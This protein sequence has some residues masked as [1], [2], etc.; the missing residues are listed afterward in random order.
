MVLADINRFGVEWMMRLMSEEDRPYISGVVDDLSGG[1]LTA[2]GFLLADIVSKAKS[3]PIEAAKSASQ[4]FRS[5][6]PD[7]DYGYLGADVIISSMLVT[8]M[9]MPFYAPHR[10]LAGLGIPE[11]VR[12]ELI[13]SFNDFRQRFY[14]NHEQALARA[15]AG[16]SHAAAVLFADTYEDLYYQ[17]ASSTLLG[18]GGHYLL[19]GNGTIVPTSRCGILPYYSTTGMVTYEAEH[20]RD[21]FLDMPGISVASHSTWQESPYFPDTDSPVVKLSLIHI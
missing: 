2:A 3:D 5:L 9:L 10:Y 7:Q 13:E 17:E 4:L 21:H 14:R 6:E 11:N 18:A 12:Q 1:V 8:Q 19:I 16:R 20:I 15:V